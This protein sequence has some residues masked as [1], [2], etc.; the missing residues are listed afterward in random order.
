MRKNCRFICSAFLSL[1]ILGGGLNIS[2]ILVTNF[3]VSA[4]AANLST[5]IVKTASGSEY[6]LV[7]GQ[8]KLSRET[9]KTHT[10]WTEGLQE[11]SGVPLKSLLQTIGI[12]EEKAGQ[13][14]I[15]A[16]AL[17]DYEVEIPGQ[18]AYDFNVLVA[19]KMNGEAMPVTQF[20]PFWIVYP[21]DEKPE[22]QDSR[23]DHRWAWQLSELL[24][25]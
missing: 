22:L 1:S 17:N 25:E 15:K 8:T 16:R 14:V 5:L 3:T 10:A 7:A 9:I 21:R 12:K 23:F 4:R 19:D 2:Q 18:D 24:V 13:I 11:F 20:G 6:Q